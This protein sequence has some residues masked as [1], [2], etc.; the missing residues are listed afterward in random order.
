MSVHDDVRKRLFDVECRRN[1]VTHS[2]WIAPKVGTAI[3]GAIH[4]G[5]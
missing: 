4:G 5:F 1:Q 3:T 2:L